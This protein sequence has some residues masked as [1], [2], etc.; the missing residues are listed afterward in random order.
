[1]PR[2][3]RRRHLLLLIMKTC[4]VV[5]FLHSVVCFGSISDTSGVVHIYGMRALSINMS[6]VHFDSL[7]YIVYF[8]YCCQCHPASFTRCFGTY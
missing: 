1:M 4:L 7:T 8:V 2:G 6:M 3:P 5:C